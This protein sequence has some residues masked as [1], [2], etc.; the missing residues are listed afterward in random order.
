ML[1]KDILE[2]EGSNETIETVQLFQFMKNMLF[3]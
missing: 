2:E 3:H 1:T